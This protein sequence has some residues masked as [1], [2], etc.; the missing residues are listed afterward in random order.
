[1]TS[2]HKFEN[3]LSKTQ[4]TWLVTG[5]AGFIGSN[6][7]H[8]LLDLKQKVI[9][10]DNFSTG[11]K[12]LVEELEK[13]KSKLWKFIEGDICD[14]KVCQTATSQ[15][16]FVLHQAAVGS[17]PRS[18]ENPLLSHHANVDGFF[19]LLVTAKDNKVKK[20]IYASSSSVYG[21]APGLP[22]VEDKIGQPLSPYAVTK[23]ID[24]IYAQI[25]YK[26]YKLPTIG[27]RYFNVFGPRQNPEGPYAAV[28]PLWINSILSN[29]KVF[30]N[31]DGSNS[32]DFC[33]IENVIQANL[34]AAIS[35]TWAFGHVFNIAYGEQ[36]TLL[37]LYDLIAR[38]IK[39]L[40]GDVKLIAPEHRPDRPGDIPHSLADVSFA[41]KIIDYD[42]VISVREGMKAT[43]K[44]FYEEHQKEKR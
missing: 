25:V 4:Y 37:Q 33:F 1:V 42:P 23:R 26:T 43:V 12:Q 19:K 6:I 5:C 22:K 41:K 29:E 17:V 30:I 24:E 16:D 11:Q 15:V 18:I 44:Y 20:F 10:V 36:T 8:R 21:D 38:E 14:L 39:A 35:S 31:G 7:C 32:R 3:S 9:G 27:L 2:Y 34:L 28:I 13:R 40:D